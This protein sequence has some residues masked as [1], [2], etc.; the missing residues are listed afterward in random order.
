MLV[1]KHR[2][3]AF[4]S[5]YKRLDAL[6]ERYPKYHEMGT[7]AT[8][9]EILEEHESY[10]EGF[11]DELRREYEERGLDRFLV[12][13]SW[14]DL[15]YRHAT[16][17]LIEAR[18]DGGAAGPW[19][20]NELVR[21]FMAQFEG[22][23]TD[24]KAYFC[25][26]ESASTQFLVV[27]EVARRADELRVIEN[28]VPDDERVH[29]LATFDKGA[30]DDVL[31][32]FHLTYGGGSEE[33]PG[34]YTLY[35]YPLVWYQTHLMEDG[36]VLRSPWL[37]DRLARYLGGLSNHHNPRKCVQVRRNVERL[38]GEGRFSSELELFCCLTR[39]IMPL[40]QWL[41]RDVALFEEKD[42]YE[43]DWRLERTRIR[44]RLTADG[45]ITP[46]WK[47]ELALF[48]AIRDVFPDALYQMRPAWL[49]RQSLDVFV[50]SLACGV[51]FQGVQ[52]FQPVE[53]FG[54]EEAFAQRLELD[55][56]KRR[57]CEENGVRLVAWPH[58]LE[59]SEANV[60][61]LLGGS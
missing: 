27:S 12:Q 16:R 35:D 1:P 11:D 52:H 4:P 14:S 21:R 41:Y 5:T 58:E 34:S 10:R 55:E 24:H 32:M 43:V 26:P 47:G 25:F 9:D 37:P 51:E 39:T 48:L 18:S 61:S 42:G 28:L 8:L 38:V 36:V 17:D 60:R 49:G 13:L 50:P 54:G 59:P 20:E 7:F 6:W 40:F 22:M 57:L 2:R 30:M 33:F 53:F 56:Q 44:T 45:A 15:A 31:L 29:F 19:Q 23:D 46:R 3:L